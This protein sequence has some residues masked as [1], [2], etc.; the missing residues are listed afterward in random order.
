VPTE[1]A[2]YQVI[3]D[4]TRGPWH[5]LGPDSG[6]EKGFIYECV[7]MQLY[8]NGSLGVRPCL[9][10]VNDGDDSIDI[11]ATNFQGAWCLHEFFELN[12]PNTITAGYEKG[13]LTQVSGATNQEIIQ[14]R[15]KG[16]DTI[17][18]LASA[19]VLDQNLPIRYQANLPENKISTLNM[20][21]TGNDDF[22]VGGDS[23]YTGLLSTADG[24]NS[25]YDELAASDEYPSGWVPHT[26]LNWRDRYW[27]WGDG[28]FD[29]R[30][31]YSNIGT[32]Q[33]WGATDYIAIG[34][35]EGKD[36]RGVWAVYDSLV[37]CMEDWQ[38]FKY[39]FVDDPDFGEIRYMGTKEIPD[40][41]VQPAEVGD[42]VVYLTLSN[43]LT[44]ISS[45]GI[46]NSVLSRIR[47]PT[48]GEDDNSSSIFF[49]R[50][51]A[52][53]GKNSIC[54]PYQVD[55]VS[56]AGK[57]TFKGD[58][59]IDLIN[60][61]WFHSLYWGPTSGAD[62][63]AAVVDAIE[64]SPYHYGFFA[65]ED[66]NSGDD[67]E[68]AYI[69]PV[70]LDRPSN[71]NDAWSSN[72]EI[73]AH[74]SADTTDRF[75]GRIWFGTY[76]PEMGSLA[77]VAKVTIEFDYWNATGFT[78]P[79]FTVKADFVHQGDEGST[80]TIGT[81]D[82]DALTS[83]SNYRS[84]RGRIVLTPAAMPMSST[85]NLFFEGIKS[86]AFQNVIIEYAVESQ[87]PLTAENL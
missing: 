28:T 69:R 57:E 66:T 62:L 77:R 50:G 34:D 21:Q 67:G 12:L 42:A 74:A 84:K 5:A 43:G 13:I 33:T 61:Q 32:I 52:A 46:D 36:I 44:V 25:G 26:T 8:S 65:I 16:V 40:F 1:Q 80:V 30:I 75:E 27:S 54:L 3:D 78:P 41:S 11:D 18:L 49:L 53:Q 14:L 68:K 47:P 51:L 70:C 4:W 24:G 73:P 37:I 86:V 7:N 83:S 60:G 19:S 63:N 79:A 38:W 20:I 81:L 17:G 10:E 9:M 85:I 29:N 59:S 39:S 6:P 71:S 76:R 82:P 58:R 56:G 15:D 64:I 48:D 2:D 55:S 22:V 45:D 72:T 23:L 87:N 31:H 35:N